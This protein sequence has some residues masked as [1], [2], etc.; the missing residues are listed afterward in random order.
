[1]VCGLN[2]FLLEFV[3]FDWLNSKFAFIGTW[4]GSILDNSISLDGLLDSVRWNTEDVVGSVET[5]D[6]IVWETRGL[7]FSQ[8]WELLM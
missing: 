2:V 6:D 1:M 7:P 4:C 8:S 5:S 3:V